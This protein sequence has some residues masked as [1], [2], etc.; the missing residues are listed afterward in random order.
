[1]ATDC[2]LCK[3]GTEFLYIICINV[4][5]QKVKWINICLSYKLGHMHLLWSG[6]LTSALASGLVLPILL[7]VKFIMEFL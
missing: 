4:S 7:H 1:M 5:L 6:R 3:V 2:V